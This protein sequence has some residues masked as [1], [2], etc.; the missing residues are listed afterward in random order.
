MAGYQSVLLGA[1]Y[2]LA[3]VIYAVSSPS[4]AEADP[5]EVL[6][7]SPLSREQEEKACQEVL[8]DSTPTRK[9]KNLK[10]WCT[11]RQ[12]IRKRMADARE[13]Q[14]FQQKLHD[15]RKLLDK[16]LDE[17]VANEQ[18]HRRL[19]DEPAA[20]EQAHVQLET[21]VREQR[22]NEITKILAAQA[23]S[24]ASMLPWLRQQAE[25][26]H[27]PLQFELSKALA[28]SNPSQALS[29]FA[30]ARIG[31]TL[32]AVLCADKTAGSAVSALTMAYGQYIRLSMTDSGYKTAVEQ[33]LQ[34]HEQHP[35]RP[36]ALW[37]CYHGMG[38]FT[39]Q[40]QLIPVSQWINVQHTAKE[41]IRA[42]LNQM[43]KP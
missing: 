42:S 26:G 16:L 29:W 32:D 10:L 5:V 30:I 23:G 8:Q 37:I 27:V 19:L 7:S 17:P 39:G 2:V 22:Y 38:A 14:L 35:L 13:D 4:R 3:S 41:K 25:A 18:G 21:L 11:G 1:V 24:P 40:V 36:S 15:N 9:I 43:G 6:Q 20:N 33:A 34:W 28:S 12:E 31:A